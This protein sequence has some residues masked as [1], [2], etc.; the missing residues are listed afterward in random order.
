MKDPNDNDTLDWVNSPG[1]SVGRPRIYRDN[2]ERQRAYR[3]RKAMS[4][5]KHRSPKTCE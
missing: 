5:T 2:A 1:R 3:E 4:A